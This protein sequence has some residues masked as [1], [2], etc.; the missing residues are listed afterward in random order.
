MAAGMCGRGR[1]RN[2][3]EGYVEDMHGRGGGGRKECKRAVGILL[4]CCF[5]Q[6][7]CFFQI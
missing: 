5:V 1:V 2:G 6:H 3:G 4:K 7:F